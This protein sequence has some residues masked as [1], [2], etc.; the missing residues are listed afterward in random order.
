M[1]ESDKQ[2]RNVDRITK[3]KHLCRN[4]DYDDTSYDDTSYNPNDFH[5]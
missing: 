2:K 1:S 3:A 4:I 5:V